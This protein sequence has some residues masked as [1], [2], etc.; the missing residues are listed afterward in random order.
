LTQTE[1]GRQQVL[2]FTVAAL[3][4][5]LSGELEIGRI[6]GNLLV[7]AK[8]FNLR[9]SDEDGAPL[10]IIDS[11]FIRYRVASFVGGDI[12]I[13]RLDLHGAVIDIFRMPG[14]TLWNYQRIL[15][16]PSPGPQTG[17]PGATLVESLWLH[18]AEITIRAPLEP[19]PRLSPE[20]Q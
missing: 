1:R 8:A 20:R 4:G 12:V 18:D 9:L 17:P 16:D 5:R 7:G 10:A 6:E 14:D 15:Q 3:G 11:A 19:D 13:N 2:M